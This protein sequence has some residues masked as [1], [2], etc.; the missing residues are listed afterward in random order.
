MLQYH[1]CIT[2]QPTQVG[3]LFTFLARQMARHENTIHV[4]KVLFEQVGL[5][6]SDTHHIPSQ[7]DGTARKLSMSIK[8]CL[9]R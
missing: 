1:D 2:L 5:L 4:N 6:C 9:S 3:I 8:Y 7:T